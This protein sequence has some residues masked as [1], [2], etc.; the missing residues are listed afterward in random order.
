MRCHLCGNELG[1]FLG[2]HAPDC[3]AKQQVEATYEQNRLLEQQREAQQEAGREAR[4]LRAAVREQ[5]ELLQEQRQRAT[6]QRLAERARDRRAERDAKAE[7]AKARDVARDLHEIGLEHRRLLRSIKTAPREA[8]LAA[9]SLIERLNLIEPGDVE[10]A[11]REELT[12]L[13]A[14]VE[15]LCATAAEA[16][17]GDSEP[18]TRWFALE[19]ERFQLVVAALSQ[20]SGDHT[21]DL[22]AKNPSVDSLEQLRADVAQTAEQYSA[23]ATGVLTMCPETPPAFL[24]ALSEE[25]GATA[26]IDLTRLKREMAGGSVSLEFVEELRKEVADGLASAARSAEEALGPRPRVFGRGKWDEQHAAWL[27]K[28]Q[29]DASEILGKYKV[30]R[31]AADAVEG[32]AQSLRRGLDALDAVFAF[33]QD[34]ERGRA[35]EEL[36]GRY[37]GLS[38]TLWREVTKVRRHPERREDLEELE[39]MADDDDDEFEEAVSTLAEALNDESEDDLR[40]VFD[41]EDD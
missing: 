2:G 4:R 31:V 40:D 25:P 30:L 8:L 17:G 10:P 15:D 13:A 3:P 9:L 26:R 12:D 35:R 28:Q 33:D 41:D 38:E 14:N 24:T 11:Q 36:E 27:A 34:A 21:G 32:Q 20:T 6:E 1:G 5:N 16:T 23:V 19:L 18:L 7:A 39:A 29:S 37:D 22:A